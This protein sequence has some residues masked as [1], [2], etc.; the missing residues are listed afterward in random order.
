MDITTELQN[1]LG[2]TKSAFMSLISDKTPLVLGAVDN[3]LVNLRTRGATLLDYVANDT[4]DDLPTKL[5]RVASFMEDEKNILESELLSFLD[6]ALGIAQTLI[7][8]VQNIVLTAIYQFLP[9]SA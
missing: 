9:K 7:N 2:A 6:I 3:Y 4:E 1:L 5:R 8:N